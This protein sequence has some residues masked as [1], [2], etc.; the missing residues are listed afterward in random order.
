MT[1]TPLT[2][3]CGAMARDDSGAGSDD[4]GNGNSNGDRSAQVC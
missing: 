2:K 1:G 3:K 4:N